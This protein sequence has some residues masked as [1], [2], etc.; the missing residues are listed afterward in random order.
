[1]QDV[2][3]GYHG[4]IFAYGQTGTGKT[5]TMT[6]PTASGPLSGIIPRVLDDVFAAAATAAVASPRCDVLVTMT[7]VQIYCE[8]VHD[9]LQP[10][11]EAL[12]I[13]EDPHSGVFVEGAACVPVRNK[14]DCLR[15]LEVGNQ[16]RAGAA[17]W[18][19]PAAAADDGAAAQWHARA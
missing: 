2:L 15:W 18:A 1:M 6:G 13:R 12:C 19:W 9:M 7:Y 4:T 11:G 17:R 14:E 16:N 8:L 3:R 5:F 10:S